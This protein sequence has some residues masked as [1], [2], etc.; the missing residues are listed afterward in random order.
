MT[1]PGLGIAGVGTSLPDRR[2]TAEALATASGRLDAVQLRSRVGFEA[3]YEPTADISPWHLMVEA[4][5]AAL[6]DARLAPDDVDLVLTVGRARLEYLNWATGLSVMDGLGA[7]RPLV[8]DMSDFTGGSLLSGLRVAA[9]RFRT[10]ASVDAALLTFYQRYSDLGD[11]RGNRDPWTW[12]IGDGGGAVVL[13]RGGEG[14]GY[15]ASAFAS[16]GRAARL[17]TLRILAVDEGPNPDG[18]FDQQWAHAK[19][20]ALR[21]ADKWYADY[22][23]RAARLLPQ[24]VEEAVRRAG[25]RLDDVARVQ[26][27]FL[28]PEVAEAVRE[29]LG[30]GA[31]FRHHNAHGQLAGT[32]LAF[33]LQELR[34]DA[35]LRGKAVV[36]AAAHFPAEFGAAVLRL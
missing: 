15:L 1:G 30:V 27:G 13:R 7:T 12:P 14:P 4:S 34:R 31:R 6:A 18:W 24:V 9:A 8:F 35:S 22:R 11:L 5:K 23:E 19:F 26:A 20:F 3:R 28:F 21:D 17:M 10:D 33:A 16:E 32:E 2:V 36:L 25:L 29:R